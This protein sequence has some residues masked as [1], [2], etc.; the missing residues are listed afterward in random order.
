MS[1]SM[2]FSPQTAVETWGFP[3]LQVGCW[4]TVV[5]GCSAMVV[6]GPACLVVEAPPPWVQ[7]E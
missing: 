2:P 7:Y 4:A 6:V 1:G 3:S 5:P